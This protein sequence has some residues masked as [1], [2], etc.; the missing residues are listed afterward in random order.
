VTTAQQIVARRHRERV[1]LL[2]QADAYVDGL[3]GAC[4][5]RAVVVF[6]SVAR[7]DF[8]DGSDV[9]V[10]VVAG[11]LP[12]RAPDRLRALGPLPPAVEVVAWTPGE[13]RAERARGNP[14]ATEAVTDGI[15]LV[16]GRDHLQFIAPSD[17]DS[18]DQQPFA[19][20]GDPRLTRS[21]SNSHGVDSAA[22]ATAR[23]DQS[24][25]PAMARDPA[26]RLRDFPLGEATKSCSPRRLPPKV[27]GR[28]T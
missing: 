1:R 24:L 17:Q 18:E 13:W 21:P 27:D 16:G 3:D 19:K 2:A 9:D 23:S 22:P 8:N 4:D 20:R 11:R 28:E 15:W 5:I 7:G 25:S 26:A 10:L 6:G 14:I 12:A